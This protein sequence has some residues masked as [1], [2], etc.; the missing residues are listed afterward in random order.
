MAGCDAAARRMQT[1]QRG[2]PDIPMAM[3]RLREDME[4]RW[5]GTA[6]LLVGQ[7]RNGML[8]R[9]RSSLSRLVA[10]AGVNHIFALLEYT[11]GGIH[12]SPQFQTQRQTPEL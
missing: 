5:S 9:P 6:M 11:R 4:P 12:L 7:I 8:E 2:M 10:S 1:T 3:Q